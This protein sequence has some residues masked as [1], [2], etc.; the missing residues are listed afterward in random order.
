MALARRRLP[1]SS[2]AGADEMVLGEKAL[3][4]LVRCAD[5]DHDSSPLLDGHIF[6]D[7]SP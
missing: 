5:F 6:C 1:V 4:V 3:E 7:S 2:Q